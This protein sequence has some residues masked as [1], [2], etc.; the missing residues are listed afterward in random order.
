M[1]R[2][3]TPKEVAYKLGWNPST[4]YTKKC[5]GTLT[6]PYIQM[7]RSLRFCPQQ[8]AQWLASRTV[9]R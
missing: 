3:L 9:N 8:F 2:L 1:E 6:I 7:D 4:I 5:R